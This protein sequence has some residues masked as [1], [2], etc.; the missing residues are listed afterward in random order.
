MDATS[1]GRKSKSSADP[2]ESLTML[3]KK[4]PRQVTASSTVGYPKPRNAAGPYLTPYAS[5]E[6]RDQM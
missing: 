2:G 3:P 5:K 4:S 6:I 1:P